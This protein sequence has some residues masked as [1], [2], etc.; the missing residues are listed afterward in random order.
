MLLYAPSRAQSRICSIVMM[1]VMI[2]IVMLGSRWAFKLVAKVRSKAAVSHVSWS[3]LQ[4][5][6]AAYL[7]QDGSLHILVVTQ[8]PSDSGQ[9]CVQVSKSRNREGG[10]HL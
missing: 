1:T 7:S 3:P 4:P 5:Y 2:L 9:D 10:C 6:Q 8:Q